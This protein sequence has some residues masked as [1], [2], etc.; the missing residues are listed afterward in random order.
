M[1]KQNYTHVQILPPEIEAMIAEGKTQREVAEHFGFKDKYVVKELLRRQ[2]TKQRELEAGLCRGPREGRGKMPLQKMWSGNGHMRLSDCGWRTNY[3]GIFC[4]RLEGGEASGKALHH[5]SPRAEHPVSVMCPFFEVSR[6]GCYDFVHRLGRPEKDAALAEMI[7]EQRKRSFGTYGYRRM[8]LWLKSQNI[9]RNP[10]TVLR[11]MKKYGLLSEI[12]RRRK[13]QQMG[14]GHLL[15]S[16][17]A[18]EY[19]TCP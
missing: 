6:S 9:H 3:C 12:R 15:H 1:G 14:N 17:Q 8:W 18:G 16:H 11:I 5:I 2:R 4:S 13:W 19:C 7:A 10:K